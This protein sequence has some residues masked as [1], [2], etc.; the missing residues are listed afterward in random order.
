MPLILS[1][2]III[3][4][5]LKMKTIKLSVNS[6]WVKYW[7]FICGKDFDFPSNTCNFKR[8]LML[9]SLLNV[10]F[11]PMIILLHI[12]LLFV[13]KYRS[14]GKVGVV[15]VSVLQA[16]GYLIA[17][18]SYKE[19][20]ILLHVL[21]VSAAFLLGIVIAGLIIWGC[22]ALSTYLENRPKKIKEPQ[23]PGFIKVLY[24][25][26]KEKLCSKIEYEA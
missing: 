18:A 4:I 8:D 15:I 5:F 11:F 7:A 2:F 23:D 12:G 13:E 1:F 6:F 10:L 20:S 26:W 9:F 21:S 16:L 14:P 17:Y 3:N 22:I 19:G 24:L 25:S